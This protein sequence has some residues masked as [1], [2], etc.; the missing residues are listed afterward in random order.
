M[1]ARATS[2]V[3]VMADEDIIVRLKAITGLGRVRVGMK[4]AKPNYKP[5]ASWSV[6]RREHLQLLVPLLLPWFGERRT[7][8]AQEL[9]DRVAALSHDRITKR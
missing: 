1:P 9:L 2:L 5:T 6:C 4:T 7:V 3:V 8:A